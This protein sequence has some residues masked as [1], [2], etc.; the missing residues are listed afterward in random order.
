MKDRIFKISLF[1]AAV[2]ILL[3]TAGILYALVGKSL[4]VFNEYGVWGFV[5]NAEWDPRAAT[6][7]YGA[8]SFIMGTIYTAF[9]ALLLCI[10]FSLPVALF[11]GEY[12]K[13]KRIAS[14]VSS[15]VD[16]LAGIPSIVYG[17]WGFYAL[18]PV[19]IALGVNAQGFGVFLASI[20]LAVMIIP[21]AS[22]LSSEFLSMVPNNL[23]EGAYSLGATRIEVI[24]K[25]SIPIAGSGIVASYILALG[26]ALGETMAVTMLIGNTNNIPAGLR[27]TGNTMASVIA[28]QFGEADGLKLSALIAIGL[29]L[30]I[31]TAIINLI[32]KL[33]MK[34][35]SA[36]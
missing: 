32:A 18:R 7:E 3:L 22:S 1:A 36:A 11:T 30:F 6:E 31:I 2:V 27:G 17:L 35:L 28:N 33:I 16:L 24:Q 23:K 21:Y 15:I 10:P 5:S 13:G 4:E 20:V 12:F 29:L 26:R 9:F 19:V 25:V 8:L 14:I 34:K